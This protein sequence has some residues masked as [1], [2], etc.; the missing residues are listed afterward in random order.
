MINFN[1]MFHYKQTI[2]WI[3]KMGETSVCATQRRQQKSSLPVTHGVTGFRSSVLAVFGDMWFEKW[4][5]H[6]MNINK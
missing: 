5:V 2:S 3:P 6:S 4:G 1:R